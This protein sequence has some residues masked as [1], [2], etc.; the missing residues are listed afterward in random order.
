MTACNP[1]SYDTGYVG[2]YHPDSN[3][4]PCSPGQKLTVGTSCSVLCDVNN[5]DKA[6]GS[7]PPNKYTCETAFQDPKKPDLTCAPISYACKPIANLFNVTNFL[8]NPGRYKGA[9][10]SAK[11]CYDGIVL[12]EGENCDIQ[13]AEYVRTYMA[14]LTQFVARLLISP[15][16]AC[17]QYLGRPVWPVVPHCL[18][19]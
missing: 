15:A 10:G 3:T 2:M 14:K 17:R 16:F 7:I 4:A 12:N 8:G 9:V 13:C 1:I 5:Y 18:C 19:R 6:G 11:P